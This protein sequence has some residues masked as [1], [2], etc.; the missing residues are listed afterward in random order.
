MKTFLEVRKIKLTPQ[1]KKVLAKRINNHMVMIYKDDKGHTVY[2]DGDKL[3]TYK[4]KRDAE[5][6]ATQF[7]KEF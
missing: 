6:S 7:A 1:G 3:D 2:V 4:T 5:K